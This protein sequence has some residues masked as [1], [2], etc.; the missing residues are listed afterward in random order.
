MELNIIIKTRAETPTL[1]EI[2][3]SYAFL[4]FLY[5]PLKSLKV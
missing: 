5:S 2:L 1:I 3:L 4:K